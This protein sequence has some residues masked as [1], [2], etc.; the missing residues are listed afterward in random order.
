MKKMGYL[1]VILAAVLWGT[2]GIPVN[3]LKESGMTSYEIGVTRSFFGAALI[4]LFMVFYDRRSFKINLKLLP[5]LIGVGAASQAGLNIGYFIAISQLGLG[6]SV[7]LLYTSPVFANLLSFLIY[8]E[9]LT[10]SKGISVVLAIIGCFLAVTGGVFSISLSLM[11]LFAGLLSGFSF[12]ITPIFSKK[13][14][15]RATLLQILFYS[16][17]FGGI[18]QLFFIDISDYLLKMDNTMIF[19][20][21]VLAIFP[22][23]ISFTLYNKGL[24]Y[25][26]PG[27]ASILC[28]MEVVVATLVAK[29]YFLEPLGSI[30]IIGIFLII[31]A[32]ILPN[33]NFEGYWVRK[34]IISPEL[35][36]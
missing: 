23:I 27:I 4:G 30:K 15:G 19:Y 13:L 18:I 22:T 36:S 14:G 26:E 2:L 32:S 35:S 24:K 31:S 33:I 6:I 10:I 11:G 29:V 8:R 16:F 3:E 12:G 20:G 5:L 21:M 1:L 25:I 17:L 34:K 7:V 9:K 28:V